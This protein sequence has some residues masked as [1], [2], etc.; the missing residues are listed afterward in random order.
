MTLLRHFALVTFDVDPDALA[1]R[2]GHEQARLGAVRRNRGGGTMRTGTP[3][4]SKSRLAGPAGSYLRG[5]RREA[6]G[7]RGARPP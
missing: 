2:F 5:T 7:L 6:A 1:V 4:E 3:E